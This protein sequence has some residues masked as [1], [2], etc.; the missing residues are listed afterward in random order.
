LLFTFVYPFQIVKKQTTAAQPQHKNT[1][2]Q[3]PHSGEALKNQA[4][5]QLR[6]EETELPQQNELMQDI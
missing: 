2:Q 4:E 5:C 6:Q 1:A 3:T